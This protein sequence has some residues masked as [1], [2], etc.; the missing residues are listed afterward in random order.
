M[1]SI[2]GPFGEIMFT[3]ELVGDAIEDEIESRLATFWDI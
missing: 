1:G 2:D 3:N